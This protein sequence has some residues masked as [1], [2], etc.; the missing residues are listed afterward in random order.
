D[1]RGKTAILVDDGIA[2]GSTM[3]AAVLAARA[4]GADR[5][6]VAA[7]TASRDAYA[8]LRRTADAVEVLSVPEPYIAVGVWYLAFPQLTDDEVIALLRR[9]EADATNEPGE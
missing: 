1:L 4:I 5:V 8:M 9:S 2:T 3:K 6:V 7:P